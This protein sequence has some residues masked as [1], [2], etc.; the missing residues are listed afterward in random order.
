MNFET[1]LIQKEQ[2]R[3]MS[4]ARRASSI[5]NVSIDLTPQFILEDS[6]E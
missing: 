4:E 6:Q 3:F 1:D 2:E 5:W